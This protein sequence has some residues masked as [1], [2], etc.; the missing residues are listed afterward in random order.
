MKKVLLVIMTLLFLTACTR[1]N[2]NSISK[3]E[4]T[5]YKN[6]THDE[7]TIDDGFNTIKKIF[8][9]KDTFFH[10]SLLTME[11]GVEGSDELEEQV[12]TETNSYDVL[13]IKFTFQTGDVEYEAMKKNHVYN[14]ETYLIKSYKDDIWHVYKMEGIPE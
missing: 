6:N 12:K 14:Y 7:L 5:V 11:Y 3:L 8:T 1:A 2:G 13:Y 10:A 4:T 9:D